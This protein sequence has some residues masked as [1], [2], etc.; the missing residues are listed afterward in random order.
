MADASPYLY[1]VILIL[2]IFSFFFSATEIAFASFNEIRIKNMALQGNKRAQRVLK[3]T[4]EY[5]KL[6][7][8]V[9]IGNN[10]CATG[11]ATAGAIL[12]TSWLGPTGA[13]VST[14]V[15]TLVFLLSEIV[16]KA[17]VKPIADAWVLRSVDI[18]I[19]FMRLVAPVSYFFVKITH[20]V[21]RSHQKGN[22]RHTTLTEQEIKY[23][24]EESHHDGILEQQES[25]LVQSALD[26]DETTVDEILTPRVDVV[27]IEQHISIEKIKDL[28]LEEKFSR[29]PVY[30]KNIDHIIG[31]VYFKDFFKQYVQK[32]GEVDLQ[33]VV[34]K[35]IYVP[36]KKTISELMK[37]LQ[38]VKVHLAV[39]TD[40]YGGTIGIITLE[41][42]IEQLVGD[43]WD[44]SDEEQQDIIEL[45]ARHYRVA[46]NVDPEDFFTHIG[47]SYQPK[48]LQALPNSFAGWALETFARIPKK[49]DQFHY[50]NLTITV[51]EL[52]EQRITRLLVQIEHQQPQPVSHQ[53]ST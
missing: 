14:V 12:F 29:L 46:G 52:T 51:F 44:E 42:M 41:D 13:A 26:F 7:S 6:L 27:A 34:Q 43:I 30:S 53:E 32:S 8:A 18:N 1:F 24:I 4:E 10:L 9:L 16:P 21:S 28:F 39:V 23:M 2:L 40:H 33:S 19:F 5:E 37:E 15:M 20:L 47:L 17:Y 48:Q 22:R 36:P 35:V 50:Q 38:R 25:E 31:V 11:V 49:G 45:D 3:A